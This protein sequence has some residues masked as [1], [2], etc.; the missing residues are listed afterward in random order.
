[1]IYGS[2]EAQA[3]EPDVRAGARKSLAAILILAAGCI[4]LAVLLVATGGKETIL[5]GGFTAHLDL[6]AGTLK[7]LEAAAGDHT[8]H[9]ARGGF[10]DAMPHMPAILRAQKRRQRGRAQTQLLAG[11]KG[12]KNSMAREGMH[13]EDYESMTDAAGSFD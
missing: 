11:I 12:D 13:T 2:C 4:A 7:G 10:Q 8:T 3:R 6:D 5:L 1:M 9:W